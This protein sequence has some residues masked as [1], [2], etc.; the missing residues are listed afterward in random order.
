MAPE[1]LD[2][3]SFDSRREWWNRRLSRLD[4]GHSVLVLEDRDG[5]T[6]FSHLGPSGN[7]DGEVY[8][9]YL[10][11][12]SWRQGQGRQLLAFAEATLAGSGHGWAVLWVLAGNNRARRFYEACG[13]EADGALKLEEIGGVQLTEVRYR[14]P[15]VSFGTALSGNRA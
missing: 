12:G 5:L 9:I 13:W 10:D 4:P 8:S 11:P 2:A 7:G 14:K 15:L 3:L 6:G 1:F